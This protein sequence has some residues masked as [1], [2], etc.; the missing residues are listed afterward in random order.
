M[1][2]GNFVRICGVLVRVCSESVRIYAIYGVLVRVGGDFFH[3]Y[4]VLVC[5]GGDSVRIYAIYGVLVRV[6]SDFVRIYAIYG[7]F[8]CVVGRLHPY[9]WGFSPCLQRLRTYLRHLRGFSPCRE[10]NF[11]RIYGVLVRV[12]SD[13]VRICA[14]YGV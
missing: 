11:V 9:L 8:F 2:G 4:G 1:S 10:G 14:I 5:V 13:S 12:G 6:C 3:I 7:V